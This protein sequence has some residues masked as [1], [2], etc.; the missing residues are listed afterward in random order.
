MKKKLKQ[1]WE[2]LN[3]KKTNIGMAIMLTA[4]AIQVFTPGLMPAEQLDFIQ[5]IG[6]LIGGFGL[7]HK[8]TKSQTV[9]NLMH[10]KTKLKKK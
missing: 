9:Q 8:G 10:T 7:A 6:G 2:Y 1:L 5:M 3:G 4:Q